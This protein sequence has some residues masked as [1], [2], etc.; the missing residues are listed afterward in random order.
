MEV[1]LFVLSAV[2]EATSADTILLPGAKMSKQGPTLLKR[3]LESSFVVEPTVIADGTWA[4]VY[5]QAF[6]NL[7][8]PS[9]PAA[10]TTVMP[11]A[12]ALSMVEVTVRIVPRPPRLALMIAGTWPL[13][14]I[15][16]IASTNQL[17]LP[18]PL[19]ESI[20]TE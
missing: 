1:P 14:M 9:L 6:G 12:T 8:L 16:S 15:Q 7:V 3:D 5:M 18:L 13:V 19:S 11:A 10:T 2:S 4:G 17:K 20:L